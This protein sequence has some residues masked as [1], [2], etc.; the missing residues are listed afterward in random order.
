MPFEPDEEAEEREEDRI[1]RMLCELFDAEIM[2]NIRAANG[3]RDNKERRVNEEKRLAEQIKI[4]INKNP[5]H[6]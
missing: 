6:L 4:A 2:A 3:I 5:D 1:A